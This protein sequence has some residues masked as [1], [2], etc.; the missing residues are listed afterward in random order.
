MISLIGLLLYAK[1]IKQFRGGTMAG[2]LFRILF[3][4]ALIA[5]IVSVDL[6]FLRHRVAARLIVNIGIVVVFAVVYFLFLKK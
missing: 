3:I 4:V 1:V 6:L 5:V 2:N